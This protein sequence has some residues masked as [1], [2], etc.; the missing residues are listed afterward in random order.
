[1]RMHYKSLF[2]MLRQ[3]RLNETQATD[4]YFSS[5]RSIEGY[6]CAQVY[7]GLKSKRLAIYGM[8]TKGEFLDTYRDF[9]RD[10]G[11]P[12]TL[13]RDNAREEDTKGVKESNRKL[14]IKDQFTEPYHPQQNPAE[15]NACKFIKQHTQTLMDRVG[16]P[17]DLWYGAAE[18]VTHV[19]NRCA[20]ESIDWEVPL[21][22]STGDTIDISHMLLY[23]GS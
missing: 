10:V 14:I 11:A 20:N 3:R 17:P 19:Y 2:S 12:H 9:I 1:M 4:T 8:R 13:R 15:L 6:T 21:T 7:Y 23:H 5:H 16:A 22:K 18:Y